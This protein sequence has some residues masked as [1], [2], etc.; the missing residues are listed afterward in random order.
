MLDQPLFGHRLKRLRL[1]LGLSQ[2]E[3]AGDGMS[4]GYLSRLESG[5]RRPSE[6]AVQHLAGQLNVDPSFFERPFGPR[7]SQVLATVTS[8][9]DSL[10]TA[11]T[12]IDALREDDRS[13]PA[14]RWQ[15]LRM[16]SLIH[17]RHGDYRAEA[18][19]L[20]ELVELSKELG[21]PALR[22]RAYTQQA[23]CLRSLGDLAG[24]ERAAEEA[25][26]IAQLE[27]LSDEDIASALMVKISIAAEGGSLHTAATHVSHLEAMLEQI[28]PGRAAEALWTCATVYVRQGDYTEAMTRLESALALLDSRDNLTLWARLRLAA[29]ATAL[30]HTPPVLGPTGRWLDE[31]QSALGFVGTPLHQQELLALRAQLAFAEGRLADAE[32]VCRQLDRGDLRLSYRDRVK[33]DTLRNRLL[34]LTGHEEEGTR[35][36]RQLAEEAGGS[37]YLDLAAHIWQALATS[38]ADLRATAPDSVP[39]Q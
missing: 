39:S 2:A 25:L 5:E 28:T 32:E 8:E 7:L 27:Q 1:E 12:L 10:T 33:V 15:A 9:P 26:T 13:D 29:S 19:W 23:R 4:T 24:A 38:L 16:V 34:I 17:N 36:L 3:L 18:E 20:V 31:A 14:T 35:N 11:T 30:Q 22:A 6:R 21:A 37:N